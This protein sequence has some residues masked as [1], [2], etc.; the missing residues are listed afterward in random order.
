MTLAFN[1]T[2]SINVLQNFANSTVPIVGGNGAYAGA[3]GSLTVTSP[4]HSGYNGYEFK[5]DGH[6]NRSPTQS[7]DHY[8]GQDGLR[9]IHPD[10]GERLA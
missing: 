7:A 3:T 4:V 1:G 8:S 9:V 2:D 10:F 5:R 6:R